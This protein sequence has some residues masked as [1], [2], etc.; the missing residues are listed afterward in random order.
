LVLFE[1]MTF[2]HIKPINFQ[3]NLQFIMKNLICTALI[4]FGLG[5]AAQ[6]QSVA[7]NTDGTAADNSALL[8]VKSSTK[9][10]LAPRMTAT[11]RAA[12]TNPATGLIVFQTDAP[13]GFYYN[14]GTPAVPSWI[15]L[16]DGVTSITNGGTGANTANDALNNLLPSQTSQAGKVLQT[17]G[18]NAAWQTAGGGSSPS[19]QLVGV[20]NASQSI[21]TQDT[22]VTFIA[23][24]S[25]TAGVGSFDGTVYT[26]G[27]NG[28]GLY[29]ITANTVMTAICGQL[30]CSIV[31]S[32]GTFYGAVG[33][34]S[35][36]IDP[37]GRSM[38]VGVIQL[39]NTDTIKVQVHTVTSP[40]CT[41][42]GTN[43]CRFT[44]TKLN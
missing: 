41:L 18:T 17:D 35:Q 37:D 3:Y 24:T 39:S 16:N 36:Y 4:A 30:T 31:T 13:V 34:Q 28:A 1:K 38:A 44:V 11:Q 2:F 15:R 22:D 26:V 19:I 42:I 33:S 7:I 14:A 12:I 27:V 21:T 32:Q 5:Y 20:K 43:L 40:S 23:S 25:P 8:D 9:G 10:L 29:L 6:A